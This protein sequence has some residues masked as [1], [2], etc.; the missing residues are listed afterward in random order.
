MTLVDLKP[1]WSPEEASSQSNGKTRSR[2]SILAWTALCDDPANDTCESILDQSGLRE[3]QSHPEDSNKRMRSRRCLRMSPI[4]FRIEASYS[5]EGR[6]GENPLN[7]PPVIEFDYVGTEEAIDTDINGKP[8]ITACG[9]RFDPPVTAEIADMVV[10][11]TRN[12]RSFDRLLAWQYY[13]AVSSDGF[14]GFPPGTPRL[15]GIKA[16]SVA[17]EDLI[18][19]QMRAVVTI[20]RVRAGGSPSRAWWKRVLHQGF[21]ERDKET[22]AIVKAETRDENGE[23]TG[24]EVVTPILLDLKGHYIEDPTIAYWLEYQ[25]YPELPFSGLGII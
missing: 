10:S 15:T 22:N 14:L 9:E 7:Q 16:N 24:E 3:G 12:V 21:R 1:M 17:F 11:V 2:S 20:R 5:A 8:I 19:F 25:V 13:G 18:Y 4:M 23:R 6:Q